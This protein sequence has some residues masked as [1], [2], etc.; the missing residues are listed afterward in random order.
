VVINGIRIKKNNPNERN[1]L[2]AIPTVPV[3][4]QAV[5]NFFLGGG[6]LKSGS[7]EVRVV[8]RHFRKVVRCAG[9]FKCVLFSSKLQI[10]FNLVNRLMVFLIF[11]Q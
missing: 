4:D 10:F 7:F 9:H 8:P 2:T 1:P 3:F 5:S 11:F 6:E